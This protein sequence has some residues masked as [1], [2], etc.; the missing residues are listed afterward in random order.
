MKELFNIHI[1]HTDEG[2]HFYQQWSNS[3]Y[4][5]FPEVDEDGNMLL[6]YDSRPTFVCLY[7]DEQE[8]LAAKLKR[9]LGENR[10]FVDGAGH[11]GIYFNIWNKSLT[12]YHVLDET[13]YVVI[14]TSKK[15]E[16]YIYYKK[17]DVERNFDLL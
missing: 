3:T 14:E 5:F 12:S 9:Y 1:E 15:N 10:I 17:E 4:E 13:N 7:A 16:I 2:K 6:V 8:T 11:I